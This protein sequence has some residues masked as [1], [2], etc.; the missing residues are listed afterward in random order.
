VLCCTQELSNKKALPNTSKISNTEP[1]EQAPN[2]APAQP[3]ARAPRQTLCKD[4]RLS[5]KKL[6]EQLHEKG[7]SIKTPAII[8]IY[9]FCELPTH[10][11][12]QVMVTVSK[13]N[14]KRAHDRNRVKRL[15]REAYRKQKHIV[16]TSL[17]EQEKQASL[18][19]IFTG[20]TLPN[21]QYAHGKIS[22][23]L[24]RFVQESLTTK[25][26]S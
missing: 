9:N 24:K 26:P 22:E 2:K 18:L 20:R 17:K 14:F 8:L 10:F 21:A 1:P 3:L 12:A 16:Y 13:R 15:L 4:E 25:N 11:P 19:F 23:L 5:R 6:I 7:V